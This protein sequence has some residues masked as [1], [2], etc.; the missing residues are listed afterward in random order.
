MKYKKLIVIGAVAVV[1]AFGVYKLLSPPDQDDT[2][3]D[4]M[5]TV[6]RYSG[7]SGRRSADA[8]QDASASA[9]GASYYGGASDSGQRTDTQQGSIQSAADHA[10]D[11]MQNAADQGGIAFDN[12]ANR[13]DNMVDNMGMGSVGTQL[14]W[15]HLVS[16]YNIGPQRILDEYAGSILTVRDAVY[17]VGTYD[18]GDTVL[19]YVVF[20]RDSARA[21]MYFEAEHE[22]E[23]MKLTKAFPVTITG[24][25]ASFAYNTLYLYACEFGY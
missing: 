20:E 5:R 22:D 3:Y 1:A 8:V 21:Y 23:V 6:Q 11:V 10:M 19:P 2:W 18:D 16:E 25:N 4:Q 9:Y 15:W 24:A 17:D 13:I 14:K 7:G 12:T